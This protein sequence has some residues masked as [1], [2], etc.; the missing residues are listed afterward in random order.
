MRLTV[1]DRFLL[2]LL[3]YVKFNEALEVPLAVTQEGVADA[4]WFS[5]RHLH[6]YVHPLVREGLVH[7]RRAHV[8]GVRQRRKVYGLT[9]SGR[10]VARRLRIKALS[11]TVVVEGDGGPRELTIAEAISEVEGPVSPLQALRLAAREEPIRLE[12]LES[13]MEPP[14][15][16]MMADAPRIEEFVGRTTELEALTETNG[17][18]LF[19]IRGVAGIG[20]SSLAA[21]ACEQLRGRRNLFWHRVRPWDTRD[22]I[23]SRLAAFLANLGKP[24]LRAVLMRGQPGRAAEVLGEDLPETEAFLVFDD[25]HQA[26]PD[27]QPFFQLL[28][29]ALA[30]AAEVRALV[31]TRTALAFYSRREVVVDSLV[32]EYELRGLEP[33]EVAAYLSH[34]QLPE[35]A[36]QVAQ[37]LHGHPLFLELLR[38]NNPVSGTFGDV[39]RY[40]EEEVYADLDKQERGMMKVASLYR[41]PIPRD[42][43]FADSEWNHDVLLSL[44]GRSLIR[45]VGQGSFEAHD[46]IRDFFRGLLTSAESGAL[47]GFAVE[48]LRALASGAREA[49]ESARCVGYLSNAIELSTVPSEQGSLFELLGDA[50]LRLG[51]LLAVSVAFRSAAKLA[52]DPE[53]QSRAHR[54]MASALNE[55]GDLAS[56]ADEIRAG[57]QAL[58]KTRSVEKG[59][60]HLARSQVYLGTANAR[61]AKEEVETALSVFRELQDVRGEAT[62]LIWRAKVL[63][64][65][66]AGGERLPSARSGLSTAL[67]LA[68]ALDDP[69]LAARAHIW[70]TQVIAMETGDT[71]KA[72]RHLAAVEATPRALENYRIRIEFL[73]QRAVHHGADDADFEARAADCRELIRGAKRVRDN[74]GLAYGKYLLATV[75]VVNGH[76]DKARTLWE[77]AAAQWQGF[78]NL[79]MLPNTLFHMG[80]CCLMEGDLSGFRRVRKRIEAPSLEEAVGVPLYPAVLRALDLFLSG[81]W[82]SSS[83][84]FEEELKK[85]QARVDED[86]GYGKELARTRLMYGI[87]LHLMGREQDARTH[88][89]W[90]Q[91]H[92]RAWNRPGHILEAEVEKRHL[93]NGIRRILRSAPVP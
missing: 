47:A 65:L 81:E 46:T 45:R 38:A 35:R 9:D 3:P 25:A 51:D 88:F 2:H 27:L 92:H 48:Q 89:R 84:V 32:R 63:T 31:L 91:E 37:G 13:R 5:Q 53:T 6:Q 30:R 83:E 12:D 52:S 49:D 75:E 19:V 43:L 77:E 42:A 69:E 85:L 15:E 59:W 87:A 80:R 7:E 8:K 71:E 72:R 44:L 55:W 20:K 78:G 18:R 1:K 93:I 74:Y 64:D 58:G 29:D 36:F 79:R 39:H 21:R 67:E 70:M 76:P 50:N 54:K 11:S 14:L 60:L 68:D 66:G 61:K 26:A 28:L 17:P 56:A 41:V 57:F 22:S 40:L 16:E 34:H 86:G 90:G 4:C 24:G 82:R 62:A 73:S 33:H 10:L 23:L